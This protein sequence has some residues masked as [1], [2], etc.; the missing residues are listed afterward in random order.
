M[1]VV[2]IS[3]QCTSGDEKRLGCEIVSNSQN[4]ALKSLIKCQS[5]RLSSSKKKMSSQNLQ[6]KK[7]VTI[8][9]EVDYIGDKKQPPVA[10]TPTSILFASPVA[11]DRK[12]IVLPGEQQPSQ[13]IINDGLAA[14]TDN[15]ELEEY[16]E[17]AEHDPMVAPDNTD[18]LRIELEVQQSCSKNN[19]DFPSTPALKHMYQA[20]S[21]SKRSKEKAFSKR[22]TFANALSKSQR[23]DDQNCPEMLKQANRP[24]RK[25]MSQ[26]FESNE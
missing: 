17:S 20:G 21:P 22:K 18:L 11:A 14:N 4:I 1:D 12:T 5:P 25:T 10:P 8:N 15:Y 7:T 2:D 16:E 6:S 24:L 3:Y 13:L 9:A 19:D 26:V 23:Y